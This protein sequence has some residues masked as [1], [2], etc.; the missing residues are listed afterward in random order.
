VRPP[1]VLVDATPLASA[2]ALRGT[3][4]ALEGMLDGLRT[5]APDARPR[6]L[7]REG[8][9]SPDGF[10]SE[11]LRWPDWPLYRIPDPWPRV[12]VER[13]ARGRA[14]Q[15]VFHATQPS[16]IPAGRTVAT[17]FDLIP[18]VYPEHYLSS[19]GRR[20]EAGAYRRFMRRLTEV[21]IVVAPSRET[22]DDLTRLARVDPA[23]IRVIPLAVPPAPAAQGE[24]P[25]GRYVLYAGAIEPHKN[26]GLAIEAMAAAPPEVRLLM[27]GPWSRRRLARLRRRAAAHGI[28][29]RV[30]WLGY[31]PAAHLAT[32]RA[33]ALAVLVPSLKEG[34]GLPVLE[35]MA[36]GVPVLASDRPSLREAGGDAARYLPPGA[37]A[38]WGRAIGELSSDPSERARMVAAGR[39]QASRFSWDATAR[40][41]A[42]AWRDAAAA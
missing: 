12:A 39:E 11:E 27:A 30:E 34:F 25:P 26:P 18:A 6:L 2:H 21:S 16:L 4:A 35:G 41:L 3:G 9:S 10:A 29:D 38:D 15:A 7:V 32:I 8:Q 33:H 14:G 19:A 40:R 5:L 13:R 17:C 31:V 23:R 36:A 42:E 1:A 37:A 20:L 22:A 28:A 24:A